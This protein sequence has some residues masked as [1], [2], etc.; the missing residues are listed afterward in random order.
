MPSSL[1]FTI[2]AP[3]QCRFPGD[4][5]IQRH[6]SD[7]TASVPQI[8]KT[9]MS[10]GLKNGL[11]R[12]SGFDM[13]PVRV[14][15]NSPKPARV[16][17]LAFAQGTNIHLGPGQERHLPHEG[18][19]V[20]Q[21]M[22]GR[23]RPTAQY[24]GIDVNDDAGLEREAD[25][26]GQR[27]IG[28]QTPR[29]ATPGETTNEASTSAVQYKKKSTSGF[30]QRVIQRA[31]GFEFED[32][33]WQVYRLQRPLNDEE[34]LLAR[35]G[36]A[37]DSL[38][39]Y[40]PIH[41]SEQERQS[42]AV[43]PY[44]KNVRLHQ[45]NGF[46]VE[47]DEVSLIDD[48]EF[49]TE[50]F[51]ESRAGLRRLGQVMTNI[52]NLFKRFST[53]ERMDPSKGQ[54][55]WSPDHPFDDDVLL[56]GIDSRENGSFKM[57]A[58]HSVEMDKISTFMQ[59]LGES[60]NETRNETNRRKP[61][62]TFMRGDR[63]AGSVDRILGKSPGI[64]RAAIDAF[65]QTLG[66]QEGGDFVD[67]A[68]LQGFTAL[69]VNYIVMLALSERAY[70]K[71]KTPLMARTDFA[72]MFAKLPQGQ[73]TVLA[74]RAQAFTS[75]VM[76]A[77][78][79][80]NVLDQ[81][82]RASDPL[83]LDFRPTRDN[84]GNPDRQQRLHHMTIAHWIHGITRGTDYLSKAGMRQYYQQHNNLGLSQQEIEHEVQYLGGL[85]VSDTLEG[86]LTDRQVAF[87][88]RFIAP[89][90]GLDID[91]IKSH[92]VNYLTFARQV[93]D[94]PANPG[95]FPD[96]KR[97]WWKWALGAGITAAIIIALILLL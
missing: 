42:M 97:K 73:Q 22:Q 1:D 13:S 88:N 16:G 92:A 10:D 53:H 72:A 91:Q 65:V 96:G 55:V 41:Q 33:A 50:P 62:R 56:A 7:A 64:A 81:Q 17:A 21:Q 6:S 28:I 51:D 35:T 40:N 24:K 86:H 60:D 36:N 63:N 82:R 3:V 49:V 61:A 39:F 80:A 30:T 45:G 27:A 68:D 44:G 25:I 94:N 54:Y 90:G 5:V 66:Y 48:I 83:I 79:N 4:A 75:A 14:H 46:K 74:N 52:K 18:W 71:A 38:R 85:G 29:H 37:I 31:V 32:S 9:G 15:Y 76:N 78:N 47:T 12:L 84:S 20:V 87:E 2:D 34:R 8:N 58:T 93:N 70:V 11:E 89:S 26:M 67:T 95:T 57:Q 77:V 69:L 43:A 59:Y 19:H 23:V